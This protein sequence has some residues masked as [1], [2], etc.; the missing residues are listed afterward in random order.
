MTAPVIDVVHFDVP[1][2]NP[3]TY[4]LYGAV[5]T[6][7]TG[8]EPNRWHHG[9]EFRSTGNYGG[10]GSFGVW[11]APWCGDP[12]PADQ[13]KDGERPGNLDPFERTV[14][15]A[16]DECDLTAP[17]RAEVQARAAQVLRLEEQVAVEREFAARMLLDA[18]DV[19]TPIPT[20]ASLAQAVGALEAAVALTNTQAY[21]HIAPQWVAL[22]TDLFKKSGTTWTSPLGNIWVIGGGY[23]DGLEDTIVATSQPYGWRDEPT[24]RTA[25]DERANIFAAVAERSVLIGYEAVIAAVTITPTP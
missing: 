22:D 2:V 11:N 9:V 23:V 13:I 1:P 21:L 14:V 5:G 10:E 16:Y 17:S 20:A 15:W 7:Q 19:A 18:A 12:V 25:I 24:V 3:T 6:W 4:G 8:D